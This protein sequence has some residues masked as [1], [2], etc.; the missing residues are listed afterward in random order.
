[1]GIHDQNKLFRA[2]GAYSGID[3]NPAFGM[4]VYDEAMR[5]CAGAFAVDVRG[6]LCCL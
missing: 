4:M 2:G 1:M 3:L 6:M 5:E